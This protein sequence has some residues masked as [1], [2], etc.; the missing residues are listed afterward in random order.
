MVDMVRTNEERVDGFPESS[1]S[2]HADDGAGHL[3]SQRTFQSRSVAELD[4][5]VQNQRPTESQHAPSL[6]NPTEGD[7]S[8]PQ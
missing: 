7:G 4:E 3:G 1:E 5:V 2:G 6:G 8:E